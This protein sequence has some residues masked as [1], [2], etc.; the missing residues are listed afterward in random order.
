MSKHGKTKINDLVETKA[1]VLNYDLYDELK[2]KDTISDTVHKIEHDAES[3][4]D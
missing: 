2:R 1:D 4:S 3:L